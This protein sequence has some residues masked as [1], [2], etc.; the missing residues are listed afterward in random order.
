MKEDNDFESLHQLCFPENFH[1]VCFPEQ[2]PRWFEAAPVPIQMLDGKSSHILF[3]S[4]GFV[5][6]LQMIK[7]RCSPAAAKGTEQGLRVR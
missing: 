6:F 3:L 2:M 1:Q 4:L 5:L 7:Q